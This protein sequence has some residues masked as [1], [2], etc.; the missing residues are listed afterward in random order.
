MDPL[1]LEIAKAPIIYMAVL[2]GVFFA[3]LLIIEKLLNTES[4]MR[5]FSSSEAAIQDTKE[6]AEED[7]AI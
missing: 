2:S 6:I 7:V 4:F 5:C 1:D 3:L